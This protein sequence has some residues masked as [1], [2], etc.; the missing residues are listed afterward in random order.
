MSAKK[1]EKYLH[2]L[3]KT[4]FIKIFFCIVTSVW[5]HLSLSIF[6]KKEKKGLP[7]SFFVP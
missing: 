4:F 1:G 3:K 5:V 7:F 2:A 6:K